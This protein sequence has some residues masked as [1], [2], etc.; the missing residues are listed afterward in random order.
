MVPLPR[1]PQP[2]ML[3]KPL[4]TET[5]APEVSTGMRTR[6]G[7]VE[8]AQGGKE[9]VQRA[10]E[11]SATAKGTQEEVWDHRRS[12][13]QLLGRLGGGGV[14]HHRS[15]FLCTQTDSQRAGLWAARHL[16]ARGRGDRPFLHGLWVVVLPVRA[17][18]NRA[19]LAWSTVISDS[20]GGHGPP[21]LG[22]CE[23]TPPMATV[24]S[25]VTKQK[26]TA[27]TTTHCCS[28][29]PGNPHI[30][31][32]PL[33]N[34]PGATY[35]CLTVTDTTKVLQLGA[36]WATFLWVFA[37]VKGPVT[38]HWLLALPTA[39][40]SLEAHEA[41]YQGDDSL[42]TL[43]KREKASK[44]A[45]CTPKLNR[46]PSQDTQGRSCLWKALRVNSSCFPETHR[47][48]KI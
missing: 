37:I 21:P 6:V 12:K 32:L 2:E 16:F 40:I 27:T 31:P 29:T 10:R 38:R 47:I 39:S 45:A 42:H 13:A 35:I 23:Q 18:C 28:H 7:C 19:P 22:I 48:R 24:T 17:T 25:E 46:K 26:G 34:T 33:P 41:P 1:T 30:L 8:T 36:A 43:R 14:N 4:G 20:R 44:K 5:Q 11:R 3:G 15:I 9:H